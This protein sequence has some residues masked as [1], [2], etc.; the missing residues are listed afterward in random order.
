[1][2]WLQSWCHIKWSSDTLVHSNFNYLGA[3]AMN[4]LSL[5]SAQCLAHSRCV[6]NH[7]WTQPSSWALTV[8]PPSPLF[9]SPVPDCHCFWISDSFSHT[10]RFAM[11]LELPCWHKFSESDPVLCSLTIARLHS[12]RYADTEQ[13]PA[14]SNITIP[15][16]LMS[17]HFTLMQRGAC[18][19]PSEEKL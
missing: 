14:P 17:Q 15:I 13:S 1:M 3:G 7:W 12:H 10:Y 8:G 18:S 16:H 5:H 4:D 11:F 6:I 9:L 19:K 2:S